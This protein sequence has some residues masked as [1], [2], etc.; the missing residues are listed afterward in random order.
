[1]PAAVRTAFDRSARRRRRAKNRFVYALVAVLLAAGGCDRDG[2]TDVDVVEFWALGREGEVVQQLVPEFERRHPRI[3]VRVQQVPWSA[4]REKLLTAYVGDAMPDVLQIGNTWIAEFVALGALAPLDDRLGALVED[5]FPG[6]LETNRIDGVLYGVP[7]YVDTRL[8]FYRSDLLASAG[9]A[10]PPA[11]WSEWLAAME[12]LRELRSEPAIL[13]PLDEWQALVILALQRGAGLLR[14]DDTRG[15]FRSP[16][17]ASA[18]AFYLDLFQR[19]LAPKGSAARAVHLY[20]GFGAGE[21][22]V[23]VSGPWNLGELSRRLPPELGESWATAPM[24]APEGDGPGVS[25]AGG[26]SLVLTRGSAHAEA[27]WVWIAYLTEAATQTDFY[28]RTGDLPSSRSAWT[29]SGLAA[30]PRVQAFWR[31]LQNVRGTPKIP[32]WERIADEIGRHAE[33]AIRG[34]ATQEEALASLDAEVDE[35]LAKRRWLRHGSEPAS[36][37]SSRSLR[38]SAAQPPRPPS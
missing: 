26:A 36:A 38:G 32:E 25:L 9:H 37:A 29:S 13:L 30:E 10:A 4:A 22:A 16:A 21:F 31:Q 33:V 15:D 27:A 20:Q 34:D 8:L 12:R 2:G 11:S 7:W 5:L 19:E 14:D 35:I 17:F 23:F 1:V 3:R 18:F 6:I 24:P 28:R